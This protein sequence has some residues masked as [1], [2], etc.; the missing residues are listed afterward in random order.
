MV[1]HM[2]QN[3]SQPVNFL[4]KNLRYLIRIFKISQGELADFVGRKQ[5]TISNWVIGNSDPTACDLIKVHQY[6]GI[7][8]DTL[9]LMDIEKSKLPMDRYAANFIKLRN[10]K[11][12]ISGEKNIIK[13]PD[14]IFNKTVIGHL[15]QMDNKLNSLESMTKKLL[16]K[17]TK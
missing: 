4:S 12:D 6:F 13:E 16:G 3:G 5:T 2:P 7:S 14:V 10:E 17:D 8:L 15:R 1:E 9:V 11:K